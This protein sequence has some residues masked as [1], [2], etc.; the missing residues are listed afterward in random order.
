MS[1]PKRSDMP[2]QGALA[3]SGSWRRFA[4]AIDEV[5]RDA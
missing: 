1:T 3:E 2:R 4:G 5:L